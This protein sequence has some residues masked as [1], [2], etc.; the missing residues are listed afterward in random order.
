CNRPERTAPFAFSPE[1]CAKVARGAASLRAAPLEVRPSLSAPRRGCTS[2]HDFHSAMSR[3][4]TSTHD[5]S[6]AQS[7]NPPSFP[8]HRP[9]SSR[10]KLSFLPWYTCPNTS[11]HVEVPHAPHIRRARGCASASPHDRDLSRPRALHHAAR[12]LRPGAPRPRP[13]LQHRP[14]DSPRHLA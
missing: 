7:S 13:A 12:L 4:T 14:V 3:P 9:P 2:H 6:R 1:G 8:L 5:P 11:A 10:P